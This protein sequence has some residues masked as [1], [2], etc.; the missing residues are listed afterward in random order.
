[1]KQMALFAGGLVAIAAQPAMAQEVDSPHFDGF[2]VGAS[3]NGDFID[4][5]RHDVLV[6]D[7]QGDGSYQRRLPTDAGTNAF[8]PGFCGGVATGR[9]PGAG[10]S[11]D[12]A[13]VGYS[14]RLGFD[15][16]VDDWAV[17]GLL[18]EGSLGNSRD[19]TSGYSTTPASY[20]LTREVDKSVALRGRIG[21]SPGDGRGLLYATGGVAYGDIKHSFA[22][23]NTANQFTVNDGDWRL[24]GQIGM[25][26]ELMITDS[27][28]FGVE[29]L[30]TRYDDDD[31][32]VTA[33]QGSAPD[34]N[35]FV[36]QSGETNIRSSNYDLKNHSVRATFGFHF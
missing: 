21:I 16:R 17:A 18:L 3:V 35:P 13:N 1:M 22:T 2:Y 34:S 9:T 10:C 19:S 32:S 14:V 5:T 26:G 7:P 12:D 23:T 30:F 11:D 28:S 15:K 36:R 27:L 20:T 25:G 24:G 31:Y 33:S 29:Y 4:D 6:F 8:S